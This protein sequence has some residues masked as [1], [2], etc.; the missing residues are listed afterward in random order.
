MISTS[1]NIAKV[2]EQVA[3]L[4]EEIR[5]EAMGEALP[6]VTSSNRVDGRLSGLLFA[7]HHIGATLDILGGQSLVSKVILEVEERLDDVNVS[8]FLNRRWDGYPRSGPRLPSGDE[9]EGDD[10]PEL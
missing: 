7:I 4:C 3:A 10:E 6:A 9:A 2:A 1:E 5:S 8:V